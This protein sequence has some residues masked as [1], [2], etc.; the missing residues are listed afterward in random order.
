MLNISHKTYRILFILAEASLRLAPSRKRFL[1]TPKYEIM[2]FNV[3]FNVYGFVGVHTSSPNFLGESSAEVV[4]PVTSER[5]RTG[6]VNFIAWRGCLLCH[7]VYTSGGEGQLENINIWCH[8]SVRQLTS[9]VKWQTS[10][11]ILRAVGR[12][13]CLVFVDFIQK[14]FKKAKIC[15]IQVGKSPKL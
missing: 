1:I 13:L 11:R 12:D 3:T 8:N 10:T 15:P 4:E 5:Q 14:Y 6:W 7:N 9:S 2:W